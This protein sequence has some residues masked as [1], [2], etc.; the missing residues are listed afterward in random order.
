M[1]K[2]YLKT[3]FRSLIHNR[4]LSF[5][6]IVGFSI[7]LAFVILISVFIRNELSYDQF[8]SN[9]DSLYRITG[10]GV[11]DKGNVFKSG[12]TKAILALFTEEI[13][14]IIHMCWLP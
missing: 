1:F 6:T 14:A 11:D 4:V 8:H 2:N 9:R 12:N 3:A 10:I 5:I 13:T 7:G